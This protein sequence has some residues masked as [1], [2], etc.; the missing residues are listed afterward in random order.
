[1]LAL[2]RGTSDSVSTS[3]AS[4]MASLVMFA[5]LGACRSCRRVSRGKHAGQRK[6]KL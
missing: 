6:R 4:G 2:E 3:M 1:M 5:R